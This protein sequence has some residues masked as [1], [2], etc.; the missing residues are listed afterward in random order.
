MGLLGLPWTQRKSADKGLLSAKEITL[1]RETLKPVVALGDGA[2]A[3][4]YARL[5]ELDPSL[6]SLFSQTDMKEQGK[7]LLAMIGSAVGSLDKLG[8][9]VPAVQRLGK[10]HVGYGVTP[11]H[12]DTVGKALIDTLKTALGD[13]F[14]PAAEKAWG[15]TYGI[16]AA[17]MQEAAANAGET[18]KGNK[19]MNENV[20]EL[21]LGSFKTM[22]DAMPVAVMVADI[23]SFQIIY[24]NTNSLETLR[25]I[26]DKLSVKADEMVGTCIDVFHKDPSHQ[27]RMLA[28]PS[29]LPHNTIIDV[30]GEKLDLLVAPLYDDDGRYFAAMLTWS[31]V[32]EKLQLEAESLRQTQMIDQMP[33]NVLM[34]DL[35]DF[36]INYMNKTSQDTLRSLES[37]L[38]IKVDEMMGHSIDV[39]HKNPEHQRKILADP[40]NLPFRSIIKVGP[41]TL[42]LL[43]S[44]ITDKSGNYL[45]PMLTWSII[46]KNVKLA[47]DFE[48]NIKGIAS[49]VSSASTEMQSSAEAMAATAEET[50]N[51]AN[52]VAAASEQLSSS[53]NE[54]SQQVTRS[55]S[56]SSEAVSEAQRS[57]AQIQGLADAAD[58]IGEVVGLINDIA[59]QT[60]LLALNATIEAARAGEAGKGFAVVASEVKNLATQTAKATDEISGQVQSIQ[61]ATR[62]A[63]SAI[64]GISK[65][66]NELSEI[67][68]AIS[69]AVEEQ[70]AATQEV[71]TNITGVTSAASETGQS[72]AQV[73]EAAAELSRQSENLSTESDDF[74]AEMRS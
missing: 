57:E 13:Q 1:V 48:A 6:K 37:L 25:S 65:V 15:K 20:N 24:M 9:I 68:T 53:I 69:S 11:A 19:Q 40:K 33:I 74:L 51:Q 64:S 38:P 45:G 60:N 17:T 46:T 3:A 63:V 55:A 7:K 49:A 12:Y 35:E 59:G 22:V 67:A 16:L 2:A 66:I 29:N 50:S 4:F 23:E 71:A 44:P 58:K 32:T 36:A 52:T 30:A 62:D 70:G 61:S 72:A 18:S 73:L 39:F 54:I 34:C 42:E 26:E 47:D 5:F 28:D 21:N 31:I 14:S 41:E 56:I 8:D 10:R 27:R 43:I